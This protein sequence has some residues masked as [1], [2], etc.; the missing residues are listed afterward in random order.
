[1]HLPCRWAHALEA[2]MDDVAKIMT[3]ECGKPL[4]EAKAEYGSG[5]PTDN[6][7]C[8]WQCLLPEMRSPPLWPACQQPAMTPAEQGSLL[9]LNCPSQTRVASV[10]WFAAEASRIEGDVLPR[11]SA[12]P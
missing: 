9:P 4:A 5:Y 10:H 11:V 12:A 2:A 8:F 6:K 7:A 1:M 3:A